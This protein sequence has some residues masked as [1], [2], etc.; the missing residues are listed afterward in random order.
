M[1]MGMGVGRGLWESRIWT[2]SGT[3]FGFLIIATSGQHHL[4]IQLSIFNKAKVTL[5][6]MQTM[7]TIIPFRATQ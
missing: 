1:G 2:G 7:T 4:I 6:G 5:P 3:A